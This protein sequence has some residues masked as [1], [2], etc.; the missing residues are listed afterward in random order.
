[1]LIYCNCLHRP[2]PILLYEEFL[3]KTKP[4]INISLLYLGKFNLKFLENID[5]SSKA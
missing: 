4:T 1:M 3:R 5:T 2:E